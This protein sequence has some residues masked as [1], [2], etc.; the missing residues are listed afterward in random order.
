LLKQPDKH[1]ITNPVNPHVSWFAYAFQASAKELGEHKMKSLLLLI[2]LLLAF[3]R[4]MP[5][6]QPR[7]RDLYLHYESG[8]TT[9]GQPGAK[10]I[11]EL[12]RNGKIRMV[13][14]DT[15]FRS[16]D[17]IRFHLSLNFEG[18]LVVFNSGTS[19]KLNRLYP[20]MGAPNPVRA[21]AEL[22]VPGNE[23]WFAFDQTPG[24]EEVTFLMSKDPIQELEELPI[25]GAGDS[26]R[27]APGRS[28][29]ASNE[30]TTLGKL[31]SRAAQGSRDLQLE[32]ASDAA[33]G[34]T[35]EKDVSGLVK[36]SV[37]LSHKN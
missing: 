9:A 24:T 32:F 17:R 7:S 25:S 27:D 6:Q 23:A 8:D 29:S 31:R 34:T 19:G 35:S 16:G 14:P 4:M 2:V 1:A 33:Y 5:G 3:P 18:Y 28:V 12:N 10:L 22:M 21:S 11:I 37:R 13:S 26:G 36:F 15:T 20:Y 30:Q